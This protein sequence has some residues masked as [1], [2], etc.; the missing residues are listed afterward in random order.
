MFDN[1]N[2]NIPHYISL[3]TPY[4]EYITRLLYLVEPNAYKYQTKEKQLLKM[5]SSLP[6]SKIPI[7]DVNL[8]I[9]I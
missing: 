1:N 5:K 7:A 6:G 9:K 3:G 8:K 2:G 4:G